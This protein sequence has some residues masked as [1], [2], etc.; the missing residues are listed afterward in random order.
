MDV[1]WQGKQGGYR[2]CGGIEMADG[3]S[4]DID[5]A[6]PIL[7]GKCISDLGGGERLRIRVVHSA[8]GITARE[9]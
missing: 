7:F 2:L 5:S 6:S 8:R 3:G 4:A 1:R 9:Q